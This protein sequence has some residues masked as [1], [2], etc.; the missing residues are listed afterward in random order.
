MIHIK[1]AGFLDT[2]QEQLLDL[3][4]RP[5]CLAQKLQTGFN[6][7]IIREA[8][9]RNSSAQVIPTML[10]HQMV[11]YHFQ[12]YAMQWVVWLFVGHVVLLIILRFCTIGRILNAVA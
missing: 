1:L 11:E 7:G 8:F 6:A 12:C 5:G 10:L 2:S 9:D 3:F 4:S